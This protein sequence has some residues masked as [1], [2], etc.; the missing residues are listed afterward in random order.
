MPVFVRVVSVPVFVRVVSVPE[1]VRV[2][3]VPELVIASMLPVLV[4][5]VLVPA[6]RMPPLTT[7][8]NVKVLSAELASLLIAY[9]PAPL[10]S[11]IAVHSEGI[12]IRRL[13][14]DAMSISSG[15]GD[16]PGQGGG[17]DY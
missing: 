4:M 16:I 2:V 14:V 6:L 5:T 3:S 11:D 7:P 13:T 15:S 17:V 12:S 1:L 9:A 8:P 10:S